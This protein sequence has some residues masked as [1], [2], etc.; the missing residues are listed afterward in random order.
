MN[1]YI[2]VHCIICGARTDEDGKVIPEH[3]IVINPYTFTE[4]RRVNLE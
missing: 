4:V 2:A 1:I 3:L